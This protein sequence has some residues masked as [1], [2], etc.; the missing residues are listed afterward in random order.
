MQTYVSSAAFAFVD[1]FSNTR[2]EPGVPTRAPV[3]EW[4]KAQPYLT[5]VAK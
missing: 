1:P 2:F 5:L 4:T 3:T